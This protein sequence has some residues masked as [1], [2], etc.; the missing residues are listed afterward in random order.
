M[1]LKPF[2]RLIREGRLTAL[3][4]SSA[5]L[6]SFY[7]LTYLAA[8][9]E[10]GLLSRLSSGP[11]KFDALAEFYSAKDQGLEALVAWLQMGLR[12]RLLHLG[13]GGYSLR[14]LARA[15]AR[16][17]AFDIVTLYNN[18]YYF[19]VEERAALLRRISSFLKPGGFLLL[20]ACCQGGSLGTQALNLWGAA[21]RGAGRLPTEKELIAHLRQVGYTR[22]SAKSLVPGDRFLSF[23]AFPVRAGSKSKRLITGILYSE[24][25]PRLTAAIL[26]SFRRFFIRLIHFPGKQTHPYGRIALCRPWSLP[27]MGTWN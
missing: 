10:A 3:L 17:E 22:V 23:Q 4:G 14:G 20:T 26:A 11:A 21:T 25:Q 18:I 12:L 1:P 7:R 27:S 15:L 19:P 6:K 13:A 24:S 8:A 9:A 5:D 2:I 16:P